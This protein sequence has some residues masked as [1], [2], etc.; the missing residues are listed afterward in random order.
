MDTTL[1]EVATLRAGY[2]FRAGVVPDPDGTISVIQ[3]RDVDASTYRIPC[4]DKLPR[5]V[6]D[7]MRSP[8]DHFVTADDILLMAR[9]P[10]N[11]AALVGLDVPQQT[12]A[13]A[14]FHI[15][16][17]EPCRVVPG[18]LAWFLNQDGPQAYFRSRN[19]ATTIPMITL[20]ALRDLPVNLPP[21]PEQH[22]IANLN[23]L[24]ER[25]R[26]LMDTLSDR[27]REL[28]R[29]WAATQQS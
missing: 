4:P 18:F 10:R 12:I 3:G 19:S 5:I 14:S 29:Q 21:L 2:P 13:V 23:D 6:P 9:G 20:A 15:I 25:E 8:K 28:L 22:H 24:F 26:Q 17:V 27:R 11:Y 7:G 16:R 1:G